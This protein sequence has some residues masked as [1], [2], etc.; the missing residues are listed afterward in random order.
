MWPWEHLAFGY[1]FY[2]LGWRLS[3]REAPS[4]SATLWLAFGTLLPDL[5]D[6][7]LSWGLGLFPSGYAI[8]HAVLVAVPV[9]VAVV[10]LAARRGREAEGI[11]FTT[12]YWSHL[13]G[14]VLNTLR[15]DQGLGVDRVLWPLVEQSP[16]GTDYGLARGLVYLSEFVRELQMED[17]TTIVVLYVVLPLPGLVLWVLDGTPGVRGLY[18]HAVGRQR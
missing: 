13:V 9:G 16:Y 6:K 18:R 5:V 17:P 1:V 8:G 15:F 4:E 7:P 3:R 14:D 12:G 10:A 2:S 11:A